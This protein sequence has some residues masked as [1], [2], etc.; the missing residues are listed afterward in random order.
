MQ[1]RSDFFIMD[2]IKTQRALGLMSSSSL[3]GV[4]VAVISIDGID[5]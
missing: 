3:E 4:N 2:S 1:Q 5:V